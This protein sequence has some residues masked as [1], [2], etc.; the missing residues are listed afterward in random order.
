MG[1]TCQQPLG[2]CLDLRASHQPLSLCCCEV[3]DDRSAT[4]GLTKFPILPQGNCSFLH[5]SIPIFPRLQ[6]AKVMHYA[7]TWTQ[8][9]DKLHRALDKAEKKNI[10]INL[11][12][13]IVCFILLDGL[14]TRL[15]LQG[16]IKVSRRDISTCYLDNHLTCSLSQPLHN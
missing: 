10:H 4:N 2:V 16:N 13:F 9:C 1:I 15:L 7:G 11:C 3:I 5:K 14:S 12:Y 6:R 8:N